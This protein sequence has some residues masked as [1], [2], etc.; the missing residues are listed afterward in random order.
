MNSNSTQP[1]SHASVNNC[2]RQTHSHSVSKLIENAVY[3][4]LGRLRW[5]TNFFCCLRN[6]VVDV[7][8]NL[9]VS[10]HFFSLRYRRARQKVSSIPPQGFE[11]ELGDFCRTRKIKFLRTRTC[12]YLFK[13]NSNSVKNRSSSQPW[14]ARLF[15]VHSHFFFIFRPSSFF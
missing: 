14:L 6:F 4:I 1:C 13:S 8:T 2:K 9:F 5:L 12:K 11:L 10:T 15:S 7:Y 3:A